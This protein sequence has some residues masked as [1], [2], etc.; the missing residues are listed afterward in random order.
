MCDALYR[1][2]HKTPDTPV[3]QLKT[4]EKELRQQETNHIKV[5]LAKTV[6]CGNVLPSDVCI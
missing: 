3:C 2:G 4:L 6:P 5:V 1:Q